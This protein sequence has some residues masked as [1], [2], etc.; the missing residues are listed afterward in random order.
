MKERKAEEKNP[1]CMASIQCIIIVEICKLW[2]YQ[3]LF[4]CTCAKQKE[5]N[6]LFR[7]E[8]CPCRAM[9]MQKHVL[10][11]GFFKKKVVVQDEFLIL[12]SKF[13]PEQ[14]LKISV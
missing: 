13:F 9:I 3:N 14:H 12:D 1:T 5:G 6:L 8:N 10:T 11:T 4:V 2:T 7:S